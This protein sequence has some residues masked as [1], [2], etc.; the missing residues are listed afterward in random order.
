MNY[1]MLGLR[2]RDRDL[3]SESV[4]LR[5]ISTFNSCQDE[6]R[7]RGVTLRKKSWEC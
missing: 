4:N 1:Y 2:M 7:A 5:K 3:R 6:K